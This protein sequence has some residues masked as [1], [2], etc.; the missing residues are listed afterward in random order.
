VYQYAVAS[1]GTIAAMTPTTVTTGITP[2]AVASDPLGH[3]L[4]V[5][6]G[7]DATI[8]QFAI[9][10][11]GV[12]TPLTPA[13]AANPGVYSPGAGPSG[14]AVDP[15][16]RFLYLVNQSNGTVAQF[17]IAADGT[18]SPMTP[19]S[20]AAGAN[21][22]SIAVEPSGHYAYV[23]NYGSDN[24]LSAG[25]IT[26]FRLATNGA[27]QALT[28]ATASAG[29]HPAA[30]SISPDGRNVYAFS[31]CNGAGCNG[32]VVRFKIGTDGTLAA[33]GGAID[34]GGHYDGRRMVFDQTAATA[35]LLTNFMGI[36]VS[37]GTLWTFTLGQDGALSAANP[38][39]LDA[40][41]QSGVTLTAA[42]QSLFV[43]A[44][45]FGIAPVPRSA[46]IKRYALQV[47]HAPVLVA[48]TD[49]GAI[50]PAAMTYV[51]AP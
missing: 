30:L 17:D 14:M 43:L 51:S 47:G 42:G 3:H 50:F 7:G 21:P 9:G 10:T 5:A 33:A 27:L 41:P 36:D 1:D 37:V 6:N 49:I 13:A 31:D 35:Y 38:P 44:W 2:G 18:L 15:S 23:A 45:Q 19:A 8:S 22:L 40:G 24:V 46:S 11:G 16:G 39:S 4:Y 32:L 20:V 26:Q 28:P 34:T 25:A 29:D 48:S 12:L